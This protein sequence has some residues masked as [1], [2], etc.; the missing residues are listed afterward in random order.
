MRRNRADSE[1]SDVDRAVWLP[2]DEPLITPERA[3]KGDMLIQRK[4]P[5]QD[6]A[7]R[8][9]PG[10]IQAAQAIINNVL[11]FL[12][13]REYINSQ[14]VTDA[15]TYELWQTCYRAKLG[16]RNN[17]V[18]S[19][20]IR[21]ME[22]ILAHDGVE[23]VNEFHTI[24]TKLSLQHKNTIERAIYTPASSHERFIAGDYRPGASP[25][26]RYIA[27]QRATIYVRAFDRLSELMEPLRDAA[28]R[29]KEER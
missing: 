9:E 6:Q 15:R 22:R 7:S 14:H 21:E 27:R 3:A 2:D 1:E 10:E 18:Y 17:R 4:E 26:E 28:R 5:T 8:N 29:R 16:Y 24:I 11:N 20:E 19:S 13:D 25:Q 23:S 12:Y